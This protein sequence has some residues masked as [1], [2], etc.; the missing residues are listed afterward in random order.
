MYLWYNYK[1]HDYVTKWKKNVCELNKSNWYRI[2]YMLILQVMKIAIDRIQ[3][4]GTCMCENF[5]RTH[6]PTR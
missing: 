3:K 1:L 4:K 6:T 2:S 5:S